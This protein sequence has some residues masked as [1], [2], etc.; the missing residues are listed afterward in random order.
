MITRRKKNESFENL[1][2]VQSTSVVTALD[3]VM[4]SAIQEDAEA[5]EHVDAV[6]SELEKTAKAVVPQEKKEKDKSPVDND[7]TAKLVLDES[8]DDFKLTTKDGRSS[9][10]YDDDDEDTYLDYDMFDFIYGLVCDCYPKPLNPISGMKQRTFMYMGSDNYNNRPFDEVGSPDN[11]DDVEIDAFD[12]HA[13]VS[14]TGDVIT[15]YANEDRDANGKRLGTVHAFDWILE[16]CKLYKFKYNGPKARRSSNSHWE[17]S[18]DIYVPCDANDY[19]MMV[20]EYFEQ[21]GLKMEDVMPRNFCVTYRKRQGGLE[22]ESSAYVNDAEVKK[23][24]DKAIVAAAQDNSE[25]LEAHVKRLFQELTAAGLTY[26]KSKV[27]QTFMDAFDD[28]E[29]ED[30]F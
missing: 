13:Q 1:Q 21:L 5:T 15:V 12:Q 30:N 22:K 26:Q 8:V 25:P 14:S 10:V 6:K 7:F 29:D 18:F 27:K 20:E 23:I 9:K 24:V 3:P 17:Y 28:G 2:R 11:T 19:P 4:A 16:V